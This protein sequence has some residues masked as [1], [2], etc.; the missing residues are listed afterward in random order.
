MDQGWV[1]PQTIDF[2]FGGQ[3]QMTS[4]LQSIEVNTTVDPK[5]F[6]MP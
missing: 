1:V 5:V 3:F 6:E 2:D 4:K